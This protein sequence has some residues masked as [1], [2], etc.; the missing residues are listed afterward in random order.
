M[1]SDT[2]AHL[3]AARLLTV[4]SGE[5]GDYLECVT[6]TV[7]PAS[8]RGLKVTASDTGE[9]L[10]PTRDR[11]YAALI[12]SGRTPELPAR[13]IHIEVPHNDARFDLPAALA[14]LAAAGQARLPQQY[15]IV[16][17]GELR[18]DS[19]VRDVP[20]TEDYLEACWKGGQ[21]RVIAG[22]CDLPIVTSHTWVPDGLVKA[23]T[24]HWACG[25]AEA[26]CTPIL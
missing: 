24:L 14:L 9:S 20:R 3:P 22:P 21:R 7:L 15:M 12:N 25:A 13:T 18:L 16:A 23:Q 26:W 17:F 11:L 10:Q 8:S 5:R 1:T 19:T 2:S 4:A 6:A